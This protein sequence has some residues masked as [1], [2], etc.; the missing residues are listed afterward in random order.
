[1]RAATVPSGATRLA[2]ILLAAGLALGLAHAATPDAS[3]R[4]GYHYYEIGDI[5]AAAPGKT[6]AGLMLGG[7]GDWPYDAYRWMIE[8]AGHGRIVILRASGATEAQD[9]FFKDIGGITAA[10]TLV[11][12]HRRAASDPTVLEIV[13]KA[14]GIFL[15]GGDQ[16][17]YVRFWKGTPLNQALDEH[18]RQGKPIGGTSAGLAILGAYAYG[19]MDG[20]SLVSADALKDPAG[21]QLTLVADFLHMPFLSTV[22][23]DS[24]FGKRERLGRLIAMVARLIHETGRDD[25]TGIGIDEYTALCID[26]NGIGKVYSGNGGY[27]WLVRPRRAAEVYAAGKPLEFRGVPVIGIGS[28]SVL[29][30]QDFR[31]ERPAFSAVYDAAGG[32]LHKRGDA[33]AAAAAPLH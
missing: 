10:Q 33:P 22:I 7:G 31:V 18:L 12:D 17:N 29:R 2:A 19:A 27:A 14:D 6:Q 8:R 13:R 1:M 25:I 32:E 9:E 30:L 3:R 26:G 11:F 24:H 28:G 21:P 16:S 20:G 15:A 23:T 4:D 5:K